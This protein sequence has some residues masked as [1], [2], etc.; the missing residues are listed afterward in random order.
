MS[1]LDGKA[2]VATGGAGLLG[3][4][5]CRSLAD[6]GAQVL[7]N[8]VDEERA[9]A[10]AADIRR[11]G[12]TADV[13]IESVESWE[14]G[15][16]IIGA[17][18]ERF[19]RVDCLVNSAA[20]IGSKPF[21]ELTEA[22]YRAILDSQLTGHFACSQHAARYMVKHGGG[23]II[24]LTSRAMAGLRNYSA[25]S[26]AKGGII[27]ATF[28]WAL[29]LARY[30]VRVNAVSPAAR[31]TEP[32]QAV[33]MQMPWAWRRNP[34]Q[35]V[36]DMRSQTPP[37]ESVAPLVVYLASD[38]SD[39]VSGQVIFLSGDSLALVR[40]PMEDRFAFQPQGW[41]VDDLQRY[42]RVTL[43]PG[44]EQP[45][46]AGGPYRWYDGVRTRQADT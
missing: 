19:G 14:H 22:E 37:P 6:E 29:E 35:S 40:H 26:A 13:C 11:V 1:R 46:M 43:G 36:G 23:S 33:S 34:G 32:D 7:I 10:V 30:G 2:V 31:A 18:L 38:A 3:A 27:S 39:W 20:S 28:T 21:L 24:N 42:F 41:S 44:L 12:G 9:R 4:A 15:E 17:C 5:F 8:D 25:Y 16:R 45:S